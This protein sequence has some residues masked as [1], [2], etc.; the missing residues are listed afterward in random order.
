LYK[1]PAGL[2]NVRQQYLWYRWRFPGLVLF[3]QVGRFCEFYDAREEALAFL[4]V[5][6]ADGCWTGIHSRLSC[7]R[8]EPLDST[9]DAEEASATSGPVSVSHSER[10][11]GFQPAPVLA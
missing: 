6:Q 10:L 7:L 8:W 11:G 2:T 4:L 3:F 9:H 5:R 1:A